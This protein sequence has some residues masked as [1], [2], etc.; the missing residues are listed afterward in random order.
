MNPP[1]PPLSDKLRAAAAAIWE[2]QHAH[3]FVRGIGDG[4]LDDERFA[5]WVRQDFVFL[6]D[7]CRVLSIA[8]ARA[9]NL[10]TLTVFATLAHATATEEMRLHRG[11]A[12]SV[13]IDPATLDDVVPLP[14]TRAYCDFLL[15]TATIGEVAELAAALLPCMWAF[16]EIGER[17]A[18]GALPEPPHLRAWVATYADASFAAQ[19]AW[20][21]G[22]VDR[23]GSDL[24]S[25]AQA[26]MERAFIL[27]SE[28]ELS[29]WDMAWNG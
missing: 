24:T 3:P 5:R 9:E 29:F 10:E 8:A 1:D 12:A 7:Y 20:C 11:V 19:A 4:T 28:L 13:G 6:I 18:A 15:R 27:S 14:A 17:I 23:L 25:T 26:R 2:R 21:R 16:S 22:I